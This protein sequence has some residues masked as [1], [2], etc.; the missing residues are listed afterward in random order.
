MFQG[1]CNHRLFVDISYLVS[2]PTRENGPS[3][4][5]DA[6]YQ[7]ACTE[8]KETARWALK[9][10]IWVTEPEHCFDLLLPLL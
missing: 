4:S 1:V 9:R 3:G 7:L 8:M 10:H 5:N 6:R 2:V